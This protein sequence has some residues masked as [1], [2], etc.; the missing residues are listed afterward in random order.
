MLIGREKEELILFDSSADRSPVLV[1]VQDGPRTPDPIEEKV[2][3]IED[4]VT[5]ELKGGP[6]KRV[7]ARLGYH[8]DVSAHIPAIS[9]V[10]HRS[11]DFEFLDRVGLHKADAGVISTVA[12]ET[13]VVAAIGDGNPVH[14]NA[15]LLDAGAIDGDIRGAFSQAGS[16]ENVSAGAGGKAQ[17][18]RIVAGVQGERCRGVAGDDRA[19][20]RIG[21]VHRFG[22]LVDGN[23]SRLRANLQYGVDGRGFCHVYGNRRKFLRLEACGFN[24]Q[25]IVAQWQQA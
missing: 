20:C 4:R 10:E 2:V 11:L 1:L 6:V 3:R 23:R 19:Q 12:C 21:G 15:I 24:L 25:M 16:V 22:L 5:E 13:S 14:G 17:K 7:G 9:G 18:I 8:V